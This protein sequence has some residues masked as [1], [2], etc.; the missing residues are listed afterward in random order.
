MYRASQAGKAAST[1]NG[2]C[3]PANTDCRN[4]DAPV[5]L[6]VSTQA[7]LDANLPQ[8]RPTPSRLLR[9]RRRRQPLCVTGVAPTRHQTPRSA[10]PADSST[11]CRR[12]HAVI[13]PGRTDSSAS[14]AKSRSMRGQTLWL[15]PKRIISGSND[16][17][18]DHI[19]LQVRHQHITL[20][21]EYRRSVQSTPQHRQ[22]PSRIVSGAHLAPR[23]AG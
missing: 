13:R 16:T 11:G 22:T 4:T 17:R 1:P 21:D 20:S 12:G 10:V 9:A 7:T 5:R 23:Q 15:P 18:V 8:N 14:S 2:R 3:R 6:P 19:R